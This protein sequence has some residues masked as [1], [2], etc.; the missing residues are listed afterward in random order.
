MVQK[1]S[2]FCFLSCEVRNV[3]SNGRTIL[4]CEKFVPSGLSNLMALNETWYPCDGRK[5]K[6]NANQLPLP[7]HTSHLPFYFVRVAILQS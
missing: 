1:Q 2:V 7:S 3:L 4:F 5:E 6:E